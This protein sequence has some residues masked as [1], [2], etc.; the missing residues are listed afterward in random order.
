MKSAGLSM[1]LA[2][3]GAGED[4]SGLGSAQPVEKAQSRQGNPR[5]SKP[6]SLIFFAPV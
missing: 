4:F 2:A 1:Q 5:K 3:K 6:F